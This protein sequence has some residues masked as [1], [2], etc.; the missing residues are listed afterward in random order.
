M[1]AV[2]M[3]I[4][5]EIVTVAIWRCIVLQFALAPLELEFTQCPSKYMEDFLLP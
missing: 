3:L 2:M 4:P 1:A 5:G